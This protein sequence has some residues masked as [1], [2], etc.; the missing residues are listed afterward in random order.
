MRLLKL[1]FFV[2]FSVVM[3]VENAAALTI[4]KVRI[5][6]NEDRTR[7]VVETDES[8]E[9]RIFYLENPNRLVFDF[10]NLKMRTEVESITVPDGSVIRKLR[11]GQY[12]PSTYR[13][14]VDLSKKVKLKSFQI[15]KEKGYNY[16]YVIDVYPS[17][18]WDGVKS[19]RDSTKAVKNVTASKVIEVEKSKAQEH[20]VSKSHLPDILKSLE[21]N[22]PVEGLKKGKKR[23]FTVMIDPGHG[24]VD[25]GAIGRRYKTR[26]KDVNLNVA[27]LLQKKI[28][29]MPGYTAKLTRSTDVFVELRNRIKR[30]Q[31][32]DADLFISLHAD[33]HDNRHLRGASVYVLSEKASDREAASLARHV[34]RGDMVAGLEL[35]E[36]ASD[37]RDILIDLT[38]RETLN[39]SAL[40]AKEVLSSVKESSV[41]VRAKDTKFAGFVVLKA[42]DIPSILVELSYLSNEFDEKMLRSSR[43]QERLAIAIAQGVKNYVRKHHKMD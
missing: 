16:R 4:E 18:N 10:P 17:R 1:C 41:N 5:G 36:E 13:L 6:Q 12:D 39:S 38:Q 30:A 40:L 31:N 21:E 19:Q 27:R 3:V 15:K 23:K 32:A 34:N 22:A 33:S 24:G 8:V 28:N 43:G 9:A 42:P 29:E 35:K 26:E 25:P 11:S 7:M 2:L 14:V 20:L 37:V